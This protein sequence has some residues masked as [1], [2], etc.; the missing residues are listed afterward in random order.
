MKHLYTFIII[1]VFSTV[2]LSAQESITTTGGKASG[3]SGTV[4]YTVGQVAYSVK[5]GADGSVLEGVQQPYEIYIISDV[6][7]IGDDLSVQA[8]PNPTKDYLMLDFENLPANNMEYQ[9]F[10]LQGELVLKSRI[11]EN[12]TKIETG[13]LISGSYFLKIISNNKIVKTYKII[14]H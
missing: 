14:K 8:Y 3:N 11:R 1:V 13:R 12:K 5:T 7:D 4:S 10:N 9:L 2:F 6:E